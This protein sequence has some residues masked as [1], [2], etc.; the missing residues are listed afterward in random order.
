MPVSDLARTDVMTVDGDQT[1]GNVATVMAEEN[2][3]SVIVEEDD[4]PIGIVT[5]RDLVIHVLEPRRDPAEM[6]AADIM[7][8]TLS[9][10]QGDMGLFEA[11]AKMQADT[12]RRLPVV[13][14]SG[15]IAGIITLDD[16]LQL[17]TE[18]LQNLASV[19]EAESPPY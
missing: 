7:T 13:D 8:E 14:D 15:L 4:R 5:D 1:A 11:T 17:L 3:G 16:I 9:T 12:V 18:E 10:V 19:V 6:T 2:V